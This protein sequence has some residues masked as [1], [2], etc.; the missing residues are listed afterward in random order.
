[1]D[2]SLKDAH[3]VQATTGTV[4]TETTKVEVLPKPFWAGIMQDAHVNASGLFMFVCGALA[5]FLPEY[6]TQLNELT[7]LAGTYLFASAKGKN[8]Q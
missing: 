5:I 8:P 1:M 7:I 6:K 3:P 2:E 4:T